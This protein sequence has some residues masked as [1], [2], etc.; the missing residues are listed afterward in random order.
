MRF[1]L[2]TAHTI[3]TF[4]FEGGEDI[5]MSVFELFTGDGCVEGNESAALLCFSEAFE[6]NLSIFIARWSVSCK[7]VLR[8]RTFFKNVNNDEYFAFVSH[9]PHL[10]LGDFQSK[11]IAIQSYRLRLKYLAQGKQYTSKDNTAF[12]M[13]EGTAITQYRSFYFGYDDE[14]IYIGEN[15]KGERTCRYCGRKTP[16]ATFKHKAH[17]VPEAL[18]N[19][20][21][22]CNE[23]CDECNTRLSAVED[24]LTSHMEMNRVV[25]GIPTKQGKIPEIEGGD[26]VVRRDKVGK[27]HVIVDGS[28]VNPSLTP[29]G[30]ISLR[31]NGAKP[32]YDND[33]YKA[34]VKCIIGLLPA[35]EMPYFKNTIS[36]LNGSL[37]D[38]SY[39]SVYKAYVNDINVQPKCKI[40]L[41][42]ENISY[43][44]YCTAL[45]YTCDMVYM[46]MIPFVT[47]DKGRFKY[48][49]DL[50]KHWQDFKKYFPKKWI[51]W[52]LSSM[53]PKS[54]YYDK[55]FDL[56][57]IETIVPEE[58]D[59]TVFES[60]RPK[61]TKSSCERIE[62]RPPVLQNIKRV[63]ISRPHISFTQG[64]QLT[65]EMKR[66]VSI[67]CAPVILLDPVQSRC[68]V[69]VDL[70]F[71]DTTNTIEYMQCYYH[72]HFYFNNFSRNID[73]QDDS[74]AFDYRLRDML[75]ETAC[76][77]GE[78]Y[79]AP[80]RAGTQFESFN[81]SGIAHYEEI[82]NSITYVL[83]DGRLA[84]SSKLCGR[85]FI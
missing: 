56:E 70:V 21:L 18:G 58:I 22:I 34:L 36:W 40:F 66:D 62:F 76:I 3:K 20:Y 13:T 55:V 37:F 30:K 28:K 59:P 47:L 67:Q 15:S 53:E 19:K 38:E 85:S 32:I 81:I 16:H 25:C 17:A 45:L 83:P 69:I 42:T 27:P 1:K 60:K 48:D 84:S 35:E 68:T 63:T 4:N 82:R 73:I 49:V 10:P 79:F 6:E 54:S 43:S 26:F 41:N 11:N 80:K 52:N 50:Q 44:P 64:L 31:I 57:N 75:W 7:F 29:D 12:L 61:S 2:I 9:Q 39:P 74:F 72:C 33:I 51:V 77:K 71:L 8:L 65:D 23:E 5:I 14:E 46:F 78:A 24:S